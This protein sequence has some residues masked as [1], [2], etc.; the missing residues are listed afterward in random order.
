MDDQ[1]F[2]DLL[3]G[4]REMKAHERGEDVPG[5]RVTRIERE[6]AEFAEVTAERDQAIVCLVGENIRHT[7]GI[8]GRVFGA[9]EGCGFG[10]G[11]P[12]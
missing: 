12:R 7:P 3:Q 9:L 10:S 4:I 11:S 6:L 5:V 8:A 1:L 2:Q